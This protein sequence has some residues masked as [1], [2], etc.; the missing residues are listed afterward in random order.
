MDGFQTIYKNEFAENWRKNLLEDAK[1][2]VEQCKNVKLLPQSA[3]LTLWQ[4]CTK[5]CITKDGVPGHA[6]RLVERYLMAQLRNYK[7][8][9]ET[10]QRR[11]FIRKLKEEFLLT[12]MVAIQLSAKMSCTEKKDDSTLVRFWLLSYGCSFT[13]TDI[14]E[15]E[16]AIIRDLEFRIPLWTGVDTAL[17]LAVEANM[18]ESVMETIALMMDTAEFFR[19]EI[20]EKVGETVGTS[21]ENVFIRTIHLAAAAVSAVAELI[22]ENFEDTIN[23]VAKVTAAPVDY[24]NVIKS[25]LLNIFG[26]CS[27]EVLF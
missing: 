17:M 22:K 23:T 24:V 7:K 4:F 13:L 25:I 19:K 3:R 1:T 6:C 21:K 15:K 14:R 26:D 2:E 18:T 16:F 12:L 11:K 9:A 10:V 20:A 5:L 27:G 8:M